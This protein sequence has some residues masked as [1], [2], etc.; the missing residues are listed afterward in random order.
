MGSG[1]RSGFSGSDKAA[2]IECDVGL[3]LKMQHTESLPCRKTTVMSSHIPYYQPRLSSPSESCGGGGGF[4]SGGGGG[5]PIFYN[6]SNQ[7]A[8]MSDI[9]DVIGAGASS[10]A[11][12]RTLHHFDTDTTFK[13]IVAAAGMAA[14]IRAPF[15]AAQ[16]QELERQT[17]IYKYMMA[18]VPVPPELLIPISRSLADVAP[19]SHSN[20]ALGL[21]YSN[22]SDPE[23]WRCRR[24]DGK[25]WR[26]SRDVAP[27][28]KYCE[29][30]AHK[31]RPRSRKPVEVLHPH[32]IN[33]NKAH[34]LNL[35]APNTT[36]KTHFLNQTNHHISPLQTAVSAT[37]YDQPRWV[38]VA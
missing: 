16:W 37:S 15:T 20:R 26:C 35:A 23:P 13:P 36:N 9:P 31:N 12:P 21:G 14:S 10:V 28:Q 29:R 7:V 18:A 11:L 27:D 38:N 2:A 5:G 6:A 4:G 3:G 25:K 24:T 8:Y 30:H 19:N 17:I 22:G 33:N 32:I 34:S 1:A